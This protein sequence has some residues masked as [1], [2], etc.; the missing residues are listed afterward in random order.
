MKKQNLCLAVGAAAASA[1]ISTSAMAFDSVDWQGGALNEYHH[2][3]TTLPTAGSPG[4]ISGNCTNP[5]LFGTIPG[6]ASSNIIIQNKTAGGPAGAYTPTAECY[7]FDA[8][9]YVFD[10]SGNAIPDVTSPNFLSGDMNA[11]LRTRNNQYVPGINPAIAANQNTGNVDVQPTVADLCTDEEGKITGGYYGFFS[12]GITG[13]NSYV[14]TNWE[15]RP[16]VGFQGGTAGAVSPFGNLPTLAQV[17]A[18]LDTYETG[19]T[20][21]IGPYSGPN[22]GAGDTPW[23]AAGVLVVA[24]DTCDTTTACASAGKAVPVP[25]FAAAAL[26]LGL[27]GITLVTGRRRAQLK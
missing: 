13:I 14:V 1:L 5:V 21:S 23:D 6:E 7:T 20:P 11:I 12:L 3:K 26:G 22:A 19:T 16:A 9:D 15:R 18:I 25:A 10:A 17:N 8:A 4:C 24:Y 27:M 2:T